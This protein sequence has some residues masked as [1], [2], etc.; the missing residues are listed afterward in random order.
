M[1]HWLDFAADVAPRKSVQ[2]RWRQQRPMTAERVGDAPNCLYFPRPGADPHARQ[3]LVRWLQTGRT[4]RPPRVAPLASSTASASPVSATPS[5]ST[6]N[7]S[8]AHP[9]RT[10]TPGSTRSYWQK[11]DNAVT[12]C[13]A[14]SPTNPRLHPRRDYSDRCPCQQYVL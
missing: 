2:R 4:C 8:T 6:R 9:A 7:V 13:R 14:K 11:A 3:S 12:E 10:E 1:A 5:Q